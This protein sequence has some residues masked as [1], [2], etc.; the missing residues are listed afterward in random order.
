M[1][2]T[3]SM[4]K[5]EKRKHT[6]KIHRWSPTSAM[7]CVAGTS[8][9]V[10]QCFLIRSKSPFRIRKQWSIRWIEWQW[11]KIYR[12][13]VPFSPSFLP[14][15]LFPFLSSLMRLWQYKHTHTHRYYLCKMN[16]FETEL[17]IIDRFLS[18]PPKIIILNV[19]S[20]RI[21]QSVDQV[22][23]KV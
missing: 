16:S 23:R 22:F 20:L 19:C 18:V 14:F 13:N 1:S 10:N 11:A 17:R 5:S 2:N 6:P 3:I 12:R 21:S 7:C 8:Q 4:L 9:A 15:S